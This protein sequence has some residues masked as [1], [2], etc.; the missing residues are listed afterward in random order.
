MRRLLKK[1]GFYSTRA[2]QGGAQ[3][4]EDWD[5]ALRIAEIFSVRVVPE[6]LVAYR[7]NGSSMSVS[8]ECM[9]KSFVFA[10]RRARQRNRDLPSA[11][12]RWS[13]G[14]F[15]LYLAEKGYEWAHYSSCLRDLKEAAC[16]NPILLLKTGI[17]KTFVKSVFNIVLGSIGIHL[18][19]PAHPSPGKSGEGVDLYPKKRRKRPF[20][21]NVLFRHL[22]L[23]RWSAALDDGG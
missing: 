22:E 8:G 18:A 20:I 7:Q 5:L 14:Y 12:F 23:T 2:E 9:A 21:L 11:A 4:C 16:A 1:S 6:Y 3:G 15:Y 17:Y 10:M 13:R 19:E